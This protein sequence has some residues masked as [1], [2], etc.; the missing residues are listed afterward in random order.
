M[1]SWAIKF[2]PE[3]FRLMEEGIRTDFYNTFLKTMLNT[4]DP[5]WSI[6]VKKLLDKDDLKDLQK[7]SNKERFLL[8]RAFAILINGNPRT[9]HW[10]DKINNLLIGNALYRELGIFLTEIK[11]LSVDLRTIVDGV[12][13]EDL[14]GFKEPYSPYKNLGLALFRIESFFMQEAFLK[15]EGIWCLLIHDSILC[16]VG[17]K[18]K[19]QE[20]VIKSC[21]EYGLDAPKIKT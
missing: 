13:S 2:N 1:G 5:Y 18:I 16:Q 3:L 4:L 8:K 11:S 15:L 14:K 19:V 21:L 10:V 20:A 6:S 17:D 9:I 7:A 12:D